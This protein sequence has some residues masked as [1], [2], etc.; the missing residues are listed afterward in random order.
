VK[1]TDALLDGWLSEHPEHPD[2]LEMKIRRRLAEQPEVNETTRELLKAYAAARPV[3]P[4][5]DRVLAAA[6]RASGKPEDGLPNLRRLDLL[7]E[8]DPSYALE[9]ARLLRAAGD[10]AGASASARTLPAR[11]ARKNSAAAKAASALPAE[12]AGPPTRRSVSMKVSK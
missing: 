12:R 8:S 2:L 4:Y 6:A 9:L 1:V 3:D 10:T 11:G 5:P 7:E